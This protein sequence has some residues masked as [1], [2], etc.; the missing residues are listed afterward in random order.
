VIVE[1]ADLLGPHLDGS[2]MRDLRTSG[3]DCHSLF[4]PPSREVAQS[5][6]R[7]GGAVQSL[8]EAGLEEAD[9]DVAVL[10]VTLVLDLVGL[11]DGFEVRSFGSEGAVFGFYDRPGQHALEFA[12][13]GDALVDCLG[14]L[15]V[16]RRAR[17][18]GTR[19]GERVRLRYPWRLVWNY[20][21]H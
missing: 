11:T 16:G 6:A 2:L 7:D 9:L 19:P 17:L 13:D 8:E 18:R 21:R 20:P 3:A 14:R 15:L 12:V 1:P 5:H 4:V 10:D